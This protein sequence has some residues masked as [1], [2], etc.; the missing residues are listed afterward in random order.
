MVAEFAR[1]KMN[2]SSD[3]EASMSTVSHPLLEKLGNILQPKTTRC[4]P[5]VKQ[6]GFITYFNEGKPTP[7]GTIGSL[8]KQVLQGI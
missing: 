7:W 1:L 8:G 2:L 5:V 3:A 4:M 6:G